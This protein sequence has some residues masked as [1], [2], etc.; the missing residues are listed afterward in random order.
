MNINKIILCFARMNRLIKKIPAIAVKT[1]HKTIATIIPP[2][3]M[4][5]KFI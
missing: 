3:I 5:A 2:K 1:E 4:K